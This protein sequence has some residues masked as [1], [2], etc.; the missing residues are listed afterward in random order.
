MNFKAWLKRIS[1]IMLAAC[2]FLPMSQCSSWV[3]TE[4]V[5]AAGNTVTVPT[6]WVDLSPL[7][8]HGD[9]SLNLV[10]LVLLY[11]WPLI[12]QLAVFKWPALNQKY[13]FLIGE[14]L[15]LAVTSY[16]TGQLI[17]MG[18]RIAYGAYVFILSAAVYLFV[19]IGYL[20]RKIALTTQSR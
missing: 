13:P 15:L 2:L 7:Y 10:L 19:T 12:F 11:S 9:A 18:E 1:A 3:K 14:L 8:L 16:F 6:E 5:D 4:Q 20:R 17:L